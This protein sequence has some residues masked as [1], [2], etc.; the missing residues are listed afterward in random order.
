MKVTSTIAYQAFTERSLNCRHPYWTWPWRLGIHGTPWRLLIDKD[1]F[2]LHLNPA[3][4]QSGLRAF[5]KAL[6]FLR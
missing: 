4:N 3:N 2:G 1:K 5:R 6:V